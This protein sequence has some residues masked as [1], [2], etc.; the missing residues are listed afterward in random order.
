MTRALRLPSE[1]GIASD[2]F[3]NKLA[4]LF[5]TV[6]DSVAVVLLQTIKLH[7]SE[8]ISC[9]QTRFD[10]CFLTCQAELHLTVSNL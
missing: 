9:V 5:G 8:L 4:G 2:I 10:S 7:V 1:T 6:Y 3:I